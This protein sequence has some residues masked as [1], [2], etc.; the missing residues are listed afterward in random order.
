MVSIRTDSIS[1]PAVAAEEPLSVKGAAN[2]CPLHYERFSGDNTNSQLMRL[3][4]PAGLISWVAAWDATNNKWIQLAVVGTLAAA[5]DVRLNNNKLTFGNGTAGYKP[6]ASEIIACQYICK[7]NYAETTALTWNGIVGTG[8]NKV[9]DTD[10]SIYA[11]GAS[12]IYVYETTPS[13]A[14]GVSTFDFEAITS[15]DGT[16]Y[17]SDDRIDLDLAVA[18]NVK[19]FA[20]VTPGAPY[21]KLRLDVN[22]TATGAGE[23]VTASVVV[24]FPHA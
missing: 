9:P 1:E 7:G 22:T 11:Q 21:L 24:T 19:F 6:A 23:N 14:G 8:D 17:A 12:A 16:T 5:R 10:S 15:A 13:V 20:L 2:Y 4:Q 3:S 18:E